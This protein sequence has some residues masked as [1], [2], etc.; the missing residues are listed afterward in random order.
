[1][2]ILKKKLKNYEKKFELELKGIREEFEHRGIKG[3]NAEKII[4]DFLKKYLPPYN[5]IGTGEVIDTDETISK[6]MDIIITNEEHP[7][8]GDL[9]NP[10]LFFIEGVAL[11]GEVKMTLTT[12]ELKKALEN[13]VRFKR[14]NAKIPNNTKVFCPKGDFYRFI[15]KRGFF[16]FAFESEITLQKILA[17]I[18]LFYSENNAPL[19]EQI[20][21]IFILDRG[22]IYNIVK[23]GSLSFP[24]IGENPALTGLI[25]IDKKMN[26]NILFSLIFW[27]NVAKKKIEY[28]RSIL[29][30]YIYN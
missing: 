1:M 30:E 14:L 26:S 15:N 25:P 20:D 13:G 19:D 11:A 22:V 27:I 7:Y 2:G 23:G 6:Q 3:T 4:G 9:S 8:L 16:I 28:P 24:K 17:E 5:R 21:A 18:K 10:E 12:N 29:L